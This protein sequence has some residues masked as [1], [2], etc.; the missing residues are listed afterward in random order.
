MKQMKDII[1]TIEP[2]RNANNDLT[3]KHLLSFSTLIQ[4]KSRYYIF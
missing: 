2:L 1:V 4:V 3:I